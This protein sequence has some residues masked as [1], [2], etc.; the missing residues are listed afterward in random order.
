MCRRRGDGVE[1]AGDEHVVVGEEAGPRDEAVRARGRARAD[2]LGRGL[3]A[4]VD[5]CGNQAVEQ[6]S[7]RWRGGRRDDS[8]LDFHTA[9]DLDV[10]IQVTVD[11]PL[12]DL[13]LCGNQNFTARS[14]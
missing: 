5:L 4:A 14:C 8:T 12:A 2:R 3:D 9:V 7:R 13:L 10:H 11:D 6:A 1:D